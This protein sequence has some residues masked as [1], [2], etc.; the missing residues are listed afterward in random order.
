MEGSKGAENPDRVE[1]SVTRNLAT[2]NPRTAARVMAYTALD[3]ARLKQNAG[4]ANTGRKSNNHVLHYTLSWPADQGVAREEVLEAV[5]GSLAVLGE[6]AGQKGGRKGKKGRIA[7]RSQF[8]TEHQAV[9]VVHNDSKALHVHVV[10]N[11]IHPGHGVMLPSSRDY[12]KLSKWAER[13]EREHG[14]LVVDQ[15]A[16]NNEERAKGKRVYD[17]KRPP[18]DAYEL[19]KA[20]RE[21]HPEALRLQKQQRAEHARLA[22]RSARFRQKSKEEWDDLQAGHKQK[23]YDLREKTTKDINTAKRKIQDGYAEKWRNLHLRQKADVDIFEQ[24]ETSMLGK[25][26]NALGSLLSLKAGVNVLWSQGARIEA[27]K[28]LQEQQK[29]D[30]ERQ[31]QKKKQDEARRIQADRKI[32]KITLAQTFSI[33]RQDIILRQQMDKA[34]LRSAWKSRQEERNNVWED[35]QKRMAQRPPEKSYGRQVTV[36]DDRIQELIKSN[37]RLQERRKAKVKERDRGR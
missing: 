14:G 21:N 27:F 19:E 10:V 9:A 28:T 35:Y 26:S 8:A 31:E 4:V 7:A 37:E 25:A 15:R 30:L 23:H 36:A 12:L 18:R 33:K 29:C 16:V 13:F 20:A 5:D 11:R 6:K 1:Y 22:K 34:A 2:G 17:K 3:Q 32:R 24:A